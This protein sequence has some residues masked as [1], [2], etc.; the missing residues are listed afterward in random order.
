MAARRVL[1]VL[2]ILAVA[3]AVVGADGPEPVGPFA[4]DPPD[5]IGARALL[6]SGAAAPLPE[7]SLDLTFT[8]DPPRLQP[9]T[10][11]LHPRRI[12]LNR[13]ET[14]LQGLA[15]VTNHVGFLAAMGSAAGLFDEKTAWKIIA[16]GAAAGALWGATFGSDDATLNTR[17]ILAPDR[18]FEEP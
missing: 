9:I 5:S 15:R 8:A 6:L 7:T 3:P 10:G 12:E 1:T 17:I 4:P 13:A 18:P 11:L 16:A 2:G 14:T